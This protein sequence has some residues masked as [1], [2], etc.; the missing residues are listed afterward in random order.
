M[1]PWEFRYKNAARPGDLTINSRPYHD[2]IYPTLEKAKPCT[3]STRPRPKPL[4]PRAGTWE[5]DEP[6]R[7][8][9]HHWH[10]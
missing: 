1:D 10:V 7:V 9:H 8:H 5:L 2:Y 3:T 4:G 6:G